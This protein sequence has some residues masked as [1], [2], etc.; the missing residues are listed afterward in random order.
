[1]SKFSL[2]DYSD[3]YMLVKGRITIARAGSDVAAIQAD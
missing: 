2:C 3:P 1:M